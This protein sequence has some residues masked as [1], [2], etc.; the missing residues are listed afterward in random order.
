MKM[1]KSGQ[2]AKFSED[3]RAL[4]HVKVALHAS[5]LDVKPAVLWIVAARPAWT[6][7]GMQKLETSWWFGI[8]VI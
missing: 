3:A 1:K 7:Q 2:A 5:A 8:K 4:R 6:S